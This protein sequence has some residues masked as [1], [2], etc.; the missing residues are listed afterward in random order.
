MWKNM[1]MCA[2][3][4]ISPYVLAITTSLFAISFSTSAYASQTSAQ[5]KTLFKVP[6][7]DEPTGL[8]VHFPGIAR[9]GDDMVEPLRGGG[10]TTF[11]VSWDGRLFYI[12][13]PLRAYD[14]HLKPPIEELEHSEGIVPWIQVYDRDGRWVRTIRLTKGGYPSRVRVDEQGQVYVDDAKQGVVVYRSDGS[15]DERRTAT[16]ADAVRRAAAEYQLDLEVASPEFLE[17]DRAG[18]VYFLARKVTSQQGST[19]NL[20]EC[21]LIIDPDGGI[22]L[23]DY[24][25]Y[26]PTGIDKYRGELIICDYDSPNAEDGFQVSFTIYN[27]PDE[28]PDNVFKRYTIT[29]FRKDSY[30]WVRPDGQVSRKIEWHLDISNMVQNVWDGFVGTLNLERHMAIATDE[31]GNLYR[32]F[33]STNLHWLDVSDPNDARRGVSL[34]DGFWIVQFT[35]DG[36]FKRVRASNLCLIGSYG[37]EENLVGRIINLWDVDKYGNVYWLEFHPTHVEIKV[38]SR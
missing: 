30:K 26:R 10:P 31:A 35:P 19:K 9:L 2:I 38:S 4:G 37:H 12:A 5:H 14:K 8:R 21:L 17:V 29:L 33:T 23:L 11:C 16:I 24:D 22:N 15:Y 3:A 1:L 25:S 13:D 27:S 7:L 36:R 6:Y 18:R 34:M 32:V 20:E 28:N